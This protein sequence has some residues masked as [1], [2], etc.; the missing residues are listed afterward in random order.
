[1]LNN[2]YIFLKMQFIL[3][4]NLIAI[5]VSTSFA[6]QEKPN[7]KL[8]TKK[9]VTIHPE[10]APPSEKK[11]RYTRNYASIDEHWSGECTR[12]KLRGDEKVKIIKENITDLNNL[13]EEN[14]KEIVKL[15]T[16]DSKNNINAEDIRNVKCNLLARLKYH[17][18]LLDALNIELS[19]KQRFATK[20]PPIQQSEF[21]TIKEARQKSDDEY[22]DI[23]NQITTELEYYKNTL[24]QV[25]SQS[26]KKIEE[27]LNKA[28]DPKDRLRLLKELEAAVEDKI[29]QNLV[30]KE[31]REDNKNKLQDIANQIRTIEQELI[32]NTNRLK[33]ATERFNKQCEEG[34][35]KK[36]ANIKKV[37]QEEREKEIKHEN[38]VKECE[39]AA[40]EK[41][42]EKKLNQQQQAAAA[43]QR[44]KTEELHQ[45][46][47][48]QRRQTQLLQEKKEKED[49]E[50]KQQQEVLE[51]R[52]LEKPKESA[53]EDVNKADKDQHQDAPKSIIT[54]GR[55]GITFVAIFGTVITSYVLRYAY[56][57]YYKKRSNTTKE[58]EFGLEVLG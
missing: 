53:Q 19:H 36:A 3:V 5:G 37:Q 47:S 55:I 4:L 40:K 33:T 57:E 25:A 7:N 27:D 38:F 18:R 41:A 24:S 17:K 46:E 13:I 50:L 35:R 39:R 12:D 52:K 48:E 29:C 21:N 15:K 22:D 11:P 34:K 43:A 23:K 54:P 45:K 42:D 6:S 10:T 26:M 2:K 49:L 51:R 58:R 44:L 32:T 14:K 8:G 16:I 1:M 30:P 31:D 56:N 20:D 9:K 28:S